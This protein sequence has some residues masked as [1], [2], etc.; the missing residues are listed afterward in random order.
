MKNLTFTERRAG[1]VI[2]LDLEGNIRLGEGSMEFRQLIRRL[3]Q[4]KEKNILLNLARISYIDSSGLG[5]VVAGY[6]S[7]QKIDAQMKL[8]HLT[9][10]VNELMM[11]TKLLTI[12]DVYDDEAEAL[13][14]FKPAA[15]DAEIKQSSVATGKLDKALLNL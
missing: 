6:T 15:G 13:K 4:D 5:E 2:I 12:F 11:I 8:L 14:S 10:R 1:D 3:V 9:R 7:L